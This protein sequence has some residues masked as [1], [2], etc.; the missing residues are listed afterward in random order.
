MTEYV[1]VVLI[2]NIF[3]ALRLFV[4]L[5]FGYL[6]YRLYAIGVFEKAQELKAVFGNANL[7]VKQV[8][9]GV[10]FGI[11]GIIIAALGV[12][13]PVTVERGNSLD[14]TVLKVL[15]QNNPSA[16]IYRL[17]N[18]T[19]GNEYRLGNGNGNNLAK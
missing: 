16:C 14:E 4:C 5:G 1:Q 8:A 17:D 13:R 2:A 9:P 3:R 7:T 19:G 15:R 11:A 10:V 12:V 6:G 18:G